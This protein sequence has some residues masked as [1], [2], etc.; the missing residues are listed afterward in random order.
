[1]R[2]ETDKPDFI[3]SRRDSKT[4]TSAVVD[5]WLVRRLLQRLDA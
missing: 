5:H 1:L 3:L 2:G 4:A